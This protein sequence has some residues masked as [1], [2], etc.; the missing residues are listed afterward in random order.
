MKIDKEFSSLLVPL[1]KDERKHLEASIL[2]E[3][4][5][6]AL[7]VWKGEGSLV[8]GHNRYEI[9]T[10]H[11][12][13]FRVTEKEFPDRQA[14]KAWIIKNQL[15]RR[16][17]TPEKFAYLVGKEYEERKKEVG[18]PEKCDQIDHIS[19]ERTSETI[20]EEYKI[21]PPTVRR[22]ATF[23][24]AID[25]I[26]EAVGEEAKEK[27]LNR[28]IDVTRQEVIEIAELEPHKQKV[29]LREMEEAEGKTARIAAR[30]A[31]HT[32]IASINLRRER[33]KSLPP[34]Q[35]KYRVIYADPPWQYSNSG[36]T[37]SA[38][39]QYPTMPTEE[40]YSLPIKDLADENA[41]L[42]LWATNPLLEDALRVCKAWGFEYKTNF[43][44]VKNRHTGGFY[45]YGQ[46][47]LLF[48]AVRGSLLPKQEGVRSSV[49]NAPR[50]EHS[51]KPDEVY[52]I[53]EAMYDG[54]YIEL[55]ARNKRE[56]WVGWG[57]DH[58]IF[59]ATG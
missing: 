9:C 45:C 26:A 40:I 27:I 56:G 47:E 6:D 23:A 29:V 59:Q 31:A 4:C 10:K 16:N 39:N 44:W 33:A 8:D 37:T 5:R 46:H 50:R 34:P 58:G 54:P 13:P 7:I 15:G 1:T 28:E 48:V 18:R 20:A 53:I 11:N 17:L 38:E 57:I 19:S 42:F 43:V 30:V 55:F 32:E 35:G 24:C 3:G 49:I 36:F 51:R 22:A 14:V 12:I 52:S 2:A 21:S 25:K 41:V